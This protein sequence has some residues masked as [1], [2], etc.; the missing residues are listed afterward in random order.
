[1]TAIVVDKVADLRRAEELQQR[2]DEALTRE[3]AIAEVLK[4]INSSPGN[5]GSTKH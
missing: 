3:A 4:V 2:L 5:R 1:M